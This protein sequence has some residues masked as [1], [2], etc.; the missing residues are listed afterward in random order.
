MLISQTTFESVGSGDT[1]VFE[2]I[3]NNSGYHFGLQLKAKFGLLY[4]QGDA[5]YS[6]NTYTYSD[7]SSLASYKIEENNLIMP[8]V[9]G[10]DLAFL[11]VYA[12][13]RFVVPLGDDFSTSFENITGYSYEIENNDMTYQVGVGL[14]LFKRVTIDLTYNGYFSSIDNVFKDISGENFTMTHPDCRYE[15]S[16][17]FYFGKFR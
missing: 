8:V 10:L 3:E 5:L 7:D 13:P 9:V 17:G 16:V 15:L 4:F 6:N 1:K 11:R 2:S 12:G 14:D